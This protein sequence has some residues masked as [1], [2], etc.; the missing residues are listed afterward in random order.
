MFLSTSSPDVHSIYIYI[1][2]YCNYYFGVWAKNKTANCFRSLIMLIDF[3]HIRVRYEKSLLALSKNKSKSNFLFCFWLRLRNNNCNN[4]L[5]IYTVYVWTL[6]WTWT[7]SL[8][9]K[10]FPHLSQLDFPYLSYHCYSIDWWFLTLTGQALRK[11]T[12]FMQCLL[13]SL[14]KCILTQRKR[15]H[16]RFEF[17][18]E[19]FNDL[20]ICIIRNLAS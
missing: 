4:H 11:C 9:I 6:D 12:E 16:Y 20:G 18:G 2:N 8:C 5:F 13:V 1:N 19:R 3:F 10:C 7:K 17:C 15:R 14:I